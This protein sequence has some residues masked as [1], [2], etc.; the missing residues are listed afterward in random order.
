MSGIVVLLNYYIGDTLKTDT[1]IG[2]ENQLAMLFIFHVV[3]LRTRL[4]SVM[5][6]NFSA[7]ISLQCSF[8]EC[9]SI[10]IRSLGQ[11]ALSVVMI[12]WLV[13]KFIEQLLLSV[14]VKSAFIGGL[15]HLSYT[16]LHSHCEV[17]VVIYAIEM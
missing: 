5:C 6:L 17:T 2:L 4:T 7:L 13:G 9:T 11:L 15:I 3:T 10:S 12:G 1:G 8:S 14:H 16:H